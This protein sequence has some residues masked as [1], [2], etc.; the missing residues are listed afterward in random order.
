MFEDAAAISSNKFKI[1]SYTNKNDSV[2]FT[3]VGDYDPEE[4]GKLV[5]RVIE[6]GTP[7]SVVVGYE[8]F[9]AVVSS[10]VKSIA[11]ENRALDPFAEKGEYQSPLQKPRVV[12]S[13]LPEKRKI[14]VKR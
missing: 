12:T 3:T 14:K 8:R 5:I 11:L 4:Q 2:E 9:H 13:T 1:T 6:D 10:L 7:Q